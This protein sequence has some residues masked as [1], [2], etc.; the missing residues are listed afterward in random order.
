MKN[1]LSSPL[2]SGVIAVARIK[3]TALL[4]QLPFVPPFLSKFSVSK[5]VAP[6]GNYTLEDVK[7][8]VVS[9]LADA[10]GSEDF[11]VNT[12]LMELGLDSL[13]GVEFRNRLQVLHF[14]G[15]CWEI[16]NTP[17]IKM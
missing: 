15:R 3:W 14:F 9:A 6:V 7:S 13:A 17:P 11:D 2:R 16:L 12:P 4:G 8:L 1:I 10:L 5:S